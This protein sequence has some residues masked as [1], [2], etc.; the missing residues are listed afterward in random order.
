MN[1][2]SLEPNYIA[3]ARLAA[4]WLLS[5]PDDLLLSRLDQIATAVA[6][7]PSSTGAPL[8]SFLDHVHGTPLIEI[9]QHYVMTF[10]MKRKASPYL[11]YWTD[12][13]TRN[14][15]RA[16]LRFKQ[17]Y[18]EAGFDL[19]SEELA[20]HLCV[21]LEFAAVGDPLTGNA[22]LAEH[23]GAI[24]LLRDALASMDSAYVHVLDS[25]IATL[26]SLTPEIRE[27]MAHLAA[28]GPPVEQVGLEPF[29]VSITIEPIGSRR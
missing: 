3:G 4:S 12:G 29:G 20:D 15:G 21:V 22:L 2:D 9:Q 28:S 23:R 18:L 19:G 26:P 17:A 7:F 14:R 5:Y 16:I 10:D 1:T 25:V 13:D 8:Q 11:S 27:R 6:E 24:H